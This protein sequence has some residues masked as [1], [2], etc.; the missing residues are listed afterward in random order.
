MID[1]VVGSFLVTLMAVVLSVCL[2]TV[3]AT[4]VAL[5]WRDDRPVSLNPHPTTCRVRPRAPRPPERILARCEDNI[6][7]WEDSP[8]RPGASK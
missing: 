2:R 1:L 8:V 6:G 5:V 7:W 4:V 3:S